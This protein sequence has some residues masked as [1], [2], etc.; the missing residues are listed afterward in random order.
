MAKYY[1]FTEH[2]NKFNKPTKIDKN[3]NGRKVWKK[4]IEAYHKK[5]Q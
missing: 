5:F 2:N 4:Y 1:L 3:D